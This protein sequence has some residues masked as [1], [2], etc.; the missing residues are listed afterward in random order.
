MLNNNLTIP[1]DFNEFTNLVFQQK[2]MLESQAN[3]LQAQIERKGSWKNVAFAICLLIT[4]L[5]S[6]GVFMLGYKVPQPLDTIC[7]FSCLPVGIGLGGVS[8]SILGI[9][10]TRID[11]LKSQ[12]EK[13][14]KRIIRFQASIREFDDKNPNEKFLENS[15]F[16]QM[17]GE[18]IAKENLSGICNEHLP[19]LIEY[20]WIKA[21][22]SQQ[23]DIKEE[24]DKV[25]RQRKKLQHRLDHLSADVTRDHK[26]CHQRVA[27]AI[28]PISEGEREW[29]DS[30]DPV[31]GLEPARGFLYD[32]GNGPVWIDGK[33]L[34]DNS[35]IYQDKL[36]A[37]SALRVINRM[38]HILTKPTSLFLEDIVRIFVCKIT[39]GDHGQSNYAA[40]EVV[41]RIVLFVRL[42][43]LLASTLTFG[44]IGAGMRSI[45]ASMTREDYSIRTVKMEDRENH[46]PNKREK[47]VVGQFNVCAG[48]DMMSRRNQVT[49]ALDRVDQWVALAKDPKK[50]NQCDVILFQELFHTEAAERL[51]ETLKLYYPYAV[52]NVGSKTMTLNSGLLILSKIPLQN[53][54]FW[55]H[56]VNRV[57][58]DKFANKGVL[59]VTAQISQGSQ[60]VLMNT[61]LNGGGPGAMD[62]RAR[63]LTAIKTHQQSYS[64]EHG[65]HFRL[66]VLGGDFNISKLTEQ[67]NQDS[68]WENS[69]WGELLDSNISLQED[70]TAGTKYFMDRKVKKAKVNRERKPELVEYQFVP[71]AYQGNVVRSRRQIV[72]VG[73]ASD[74]AAIVCE[75]TLK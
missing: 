45:T 66:E 74:G 8:V 75:Y 3:L 20:L 7:F 65:G 55:P 72:D 47:I 27:K 22:L 34:Q 35:Y 1:N 37:R 60:V 17:Y 54:R 67:G 16:K 21:Q 6:V 5:L 10:E 9:F 28:I 2:V 43:F 24:E 69:V 12:L 50:L 18:I 13:Y 39:P 63:Q 52:Y 25:E 26:S 31:L 59:A 36:R 41:K 15:L 64:I 48:P 58:D 38:G 68:D 53:P 19:S 70:L 73:D 61:H 33:R 49:P 23:S 44:V 57:G 51:I 71:A 30:L 56:G 46:V 62:C 4:G 42:P 29:A 14:E 11:K 32:E 40:L